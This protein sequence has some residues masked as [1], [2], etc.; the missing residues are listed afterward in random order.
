MK[1]V[2]ICVTKHD[3]SKHIYIVQWQ[4]KL[5]N[6]HYLTYFFVVRILKI[7]SFGHFQVYEQ[8]LPGREG[9]G[10]ERRGRGGERGAWGEMAHTMYAHMNK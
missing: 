1:I 7:C 8:V 5:F 4:I 2:Y 3:I 6:I 10:G 9:D